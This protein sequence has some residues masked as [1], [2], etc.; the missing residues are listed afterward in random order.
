MS[1]LRK[2]IFLIFVAIY[3]GVTPLTILYALGYIFNP[4]QQT[5]LQT[6][7]V[8]LNSDPP[9][10]NITI[11][12][13][14]LKD[15][16]PLVLR[17]LRPG[18]HD[19]QISLPGRHPWHKQVDV[20]P[21]RAIR[22][23]EILLFPLSLE[24]E[25]LGNFPV[26]R[27]ASTPGGKYLLIQGGD[28]TSWLYLFDSE[29]K[30][31]EPVFSRSRNHKAEVNEIYLSPTG[32]RA[33][34]LLQKKGK[35]HPL[36][37]R[38][39]DPLQMSDLTDF[40]EEPFRDLR[41][42]LNHKDSL[43]Y[44]KENTLM[45]L[46]LDRKILYPALTKKVRGYTPHERGLF[47][48]NETGQFL[49]LNEK[50]KI[51]DVLLDDPSKANLI[52]GADPKES[53]SIFFL[54]NP[55]VFSALNDALAIFLSEKGRLLSNKLPY[56]LDERVEGVAVAVSHSRLAYRKGE[57]LWM[58]D[59]EQ[60]GEKVFFERGP[61]PK[62]IYKGKNGLSHLVWFY[63]DR[64]LLFLEGDRLMV[65][66]FEGEGK[67]VELLKVSSRTPE[68][69]FDPRRGFLYFTHPEGDRLAR[70][71]LFEEPGFFPRFKESS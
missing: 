45:R 32:D 55:F 58:V 69:Y 70:V 56:F 6:G 42:S 59:F 25:I 18:V 10:A 11:D 19:I 12:G 1:T 71:E 53:Y 26:S 20:K 65:Q 9:R 31:F 62:K 38:L 27:I 17:N 36:F 24:P 8:S 23:E 57:E 49:R 29:G 4:V 22:F 47:V 54:P 46:D 39:T 52:F 13:T 2:A 5:L 50:G 64:Y 48:L 41:W 68:A 35:I 66:D 28:R 43:F 37:V 16:T 63:H 44:L 60:E 21:E 30:K 34:I 3:L 67:P 15:K 40:L 14:L 7:L 33:M 51:Q 61:T